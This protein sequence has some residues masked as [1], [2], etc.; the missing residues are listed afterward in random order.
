VQAGLVDG[1]AAIGQPE[2]IENPCPDRLR[3]ALFTFA[4]GYWIGLRGKAALPALSAADETAFAAFP[5]RVLI[6]ETDGRGSRSPKRAADAPSP[7]LRRCAERGVPVQATAE[8]G[9]RWLALPFAGQDGKVAGVLVAAGDASSEDWRLRLVL[10]NVDEGVSLVD[11]EGRIVLYNKRLPE[12]LDLPESLLARHPTQDEIVRFQIERGD[13]AALGGDAA[14]QSERLNTLVREAKGPVRYERAGRNG[15]I[16][17]VMINPLADGRQIRTF[18]DVTA[19]R[20]AERRLAENERLLREI[21]DSLDAEIVVYGADGGYLLGNR[22]FH[23]LYPHFPPDEE[24]RGKSYGELMRLSIAAG[25]I[26]DPA[27]RRDPEAYIADRTA[28]AKASP[29]IKEHRQSSGRWSMVRTHHTPDGLTIYLL[30]DI[31]ERKRIEEELEEKTEHL[32]VTLEYMGDGITVFD[33]ELNTL[34]YNRPLLEFFN[35]PE[36]LAEGKPT[37]ERALRFMVERGD[38]GPGDPD[39]LV[40][41]LL[42]GFRRRTSDVQ[43]FTLA[44]GRVVSISHIP[45]PGGR[46]LRRYTDVTAFKRAE[47]AVAE[48]AALLQATLEHMGDG[49]S[50]FDRDLNVVVYNRRVLEYFELPEE[51]V[52]LHQPAARGIRFMVER[53]DYGPGDP[54]T[55]LAQTLDAFLTPRSDVREHT[56]RTGRVLSIAHRPLPDG[57]ILRRYTDV[58]AW[59]RAEAEIAEQSAILQATLEN[60]G[61]GIAL[62]DPDL[63]LIIYNRPALLYF[64][65][66]EQDLKKDPTA[67]GII[68]YNARRGDYGP[69]DPEDHVRKYLESFQSSVPHSFERIQ[70]DGKVIEIHHNP[71]PDGRIVRRYSDITARRLAEQRLAESER[72]LRETLDNMDAEVIVYDAEGRFLLGNKRFHEFYPHYPPDEKLKGRTFDDLLRLSMEAGAVQDPQALIDPEAYVARRVATR[73]KDPPFYEQ[74]HSSGR[75]SFVR[76]HRTES[77]LT[78]MLFFDISERKRIEEE[79]ATKSALLAAT[80][81]SIRDGISMLDENLNIVATNRLLTEIFKL[82]KDYF[83]ELPQPITRVLTHFAERGDYGSGDRKEI[84]ARRV[85]GFR[86]REPWTQEL[87]MSDGRIIEIHHNPLA[88][89]RLL[90]SYSDITERKKLENELK[91][92][93]A[94]A[95]AAATAKSAFL[96]NMSHEIRTPLNG[97]IANLELLGL[98]RVDGDQA[99]LVSSAEVAARALLT[100]IG[101]ILDFS[102]IEANRVEIELIEVDPGR[103]VEEV[104]A[105]LSTAARQKGIELTATIGEAV[106]GLVL[107]DPVRLRQV[108]LNLVGNALKFTGEGWVDV[109]LSSEGDAETAL[110]RFEVEDTGIGID[111]ERAGDLFAPF[112]QADPST[113]RRFGGTGLGLAITR[114][115]VELMGGEIG[116]DGRIGVGTTFRFSIPAGIVDA[117]PSARRSP[118]DVDDRPVA[119]PR[120]ASGLPILVVEDNQ[121]NQVVARRQLRALGL[122]CVTVGDGKAGLAALERGRFPLV[123]LDLSMPEMDG[124]EMALQVRANEKAH[125]EASPLPIVALSANVAESEQAR[126]L[127][128]GMDGYLAKPVDLHRLAEMLRRWIPVDGEMR[129]SPRPGGADPVDP[130]APIAVA[131]LMEAL[132]T[133]DPAE[134]ADVLGV[135]G[136][137]L[138]ALIETLSAAASRNEPRGL[139]D[140]AHA[141]RGAARNARADRLADLCESM[142]IAGHRAEWAEV[143]RLLPEVDRAYRETAAFVASYIAERRT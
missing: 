54:D 15:R 16:I 11:A 66:S 58:T 55:L 83:K 98:T 128:A 17:E 86:L 118:A 112:T 32:R 85:A 61:D 114:Q 77:G 27:A 36:H 119:L 20:T 94:K 37:A 113:H 102:K 109:R 5:G 99:E 115:L 2:L 95:E 47:A 57:K 140:A 24:L 1:G 122:D 108:L 28:K 39:A 132:A 78:I 6:L 130:A 106:P 43:E 135:F 111:K 107:A 35:L 18:T 45:L 101:E 96:A 10:D 9:R 92:A 46:T 124:F 40:A 4:H 68:R 105:L 74:L 52:A 116:Y 110:L 26:T 139:R 56:L 79:L 42:E 136:S 75:W 59:R 50:V 63:R 91:D 104:V 71:L 134:I 44:D 90:R 7:L 137:V 13:L 21:I 73:A 82:P 25:V 81:E 19:R 38:Y 22:R 33:S 14:A 133:D 120:F 23:E 129:F 76:R 48:Q 93:R 80:L 127:A 117:A 3:D 29:P 8:S 88:D 89:G 123:L 121:M 70:S 84:V 49:I 12:I 67:A 141:A 41:Q 62:F 87:A 97:V 103:V 53:G 72:L 126:A 30:L 125:G 31:T 142:E 131:A 138:P 69:G 60:M 65:V 100:I 143:A 51:L 34:L 64:D